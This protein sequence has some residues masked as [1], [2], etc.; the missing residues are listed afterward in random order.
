MAKITSWFQGILQ[1]EEHKTAIILVSTEIFEGE[2]T[3]QNKQI[4]SKRKKNVRIPGKTFFW[5]FH[6]HVICF[7]KSSTIQFSLL[8]F[9]VWVQ[10]KKRITFQSL[11]SHT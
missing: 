9:R 4:S 6:Q 2:K 10:M 1:S 11:K 3:Q 7:T 5:G 8:Y